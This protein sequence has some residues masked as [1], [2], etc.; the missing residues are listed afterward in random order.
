MSQPLYNQIGSSYNATRQADP[1][2]IQKILTSLNPIANGKYLDLACGTGNYTIAYQA[3]GIAMIGVD[4]SEVMLEQARSKNPSIRWVIGDAKNL[5]FNDQSFAGITC[6]NAIHH[7]NNLSAVISECARLLS[8]GRL[9][10]FCSIQEQM[11]NYWLNH[12]FPKMMERSIEQMPTK[13]KIVECLNK[14]NFKNIA[15]ESF[16]VTEDLKDLFL[17]SG[18]QRPEFYLNEK[19]RSNISSFASLSAVEEVN[20][21]ISKL[22]K[23]IDAGVIQDIISSFSDE[24]GD[25]MIISADK[26]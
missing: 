5:P 21:G 9:V 8:A 12:Y 3:T 18:K 16:F 7:F 24:L 17:Y 2:I 4:H 20:Q 23:D 1:E 10:I 19:F 14:A 25:Y 26:G 11:K 6:T 15:C 22:K 13:T